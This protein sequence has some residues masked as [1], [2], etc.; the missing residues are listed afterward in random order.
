MTVEAHKET[1]DFQAEVSQVLNLVIRSLYS[2][3]EIFLRE[4]VSNAS[5]A[6]EKL[7][8]EAL[9]DEALFEDDPELRVRVTLD[10]EAGTVTISDNGIG[11][12]RQEVAETIGTIA[13]SGTR[14]FFEAMSGDQTKDS[15][16][17]GQFGVGFYSA[18]IVADKVTLLTRR[19]GLGQEHGV[20]WESDGEGSF[21]IENVDKATRGTDVVLHLREDE[22]E[23]IE[24]YR[25]R[26]IISKFSDHITIPVEME[27]EHYGEDEEKP[28][29]AEFERVNK[30]TALWMRNR[31]DISEEEYHEFYKHVSHDFE[32]P[33]THVHNKVEGNNE[34]TALL[35]IPQRAPFDLWDR[36]Q[37]HGVKLFVRRVFI[38]DEADKLMPRYLRF[39]KGVVDSDDLP[40]NVSREILQHN[41]K[42][43]TIRQANVKRIMSALEKLAESDKEKYQ[44]FWDEFGKV[45]KEGP[46][47]DYANRDRIAGLLRF[48]TTHNETDEQ[49][50]S[51]ADYVSRMQEGQDKIYYITADSPAAARFSPH[52]EV[53]KKK[54]V[55]VLLLS[56]RVDEWLVTSLTESDGKQLQSVAKGA[57]DLG[58]LE[59]KEEKESSEKQSEEHKELLQRMQDVLGEAVKEIRVSQRLTDSP[60]CLVVEEHDMSANLARV[61]KSV[62]QDAPQTKPIM[63][64]N[65]EHPLVERLEGEQDGDKFGD[66]TKVLFDQAQLAEGGQLDDPAAFVRRLNSLMLKLTAG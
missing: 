5:D 30:G 58:E 62:G 35:Y 15:E 21:T 10:K 20:R 52:L 17:I 51:L 24:S 60:A 16:L 49:N 63:E 45:M 53:L 27:K 26:S 14:K 6:A 46:A 47:E 1:L 33:L 57:L 40:L 22:K 39:V 64:I 11:M 59:D 36:D 9:T 29:T 34:Y 23:F 43:D 61:L 4:L 37:K 31:S 28:K 54:G 19:A 18:F 32:N 42:I 50:V 66:L 2:N 7:R 65:A 25:L 13:S 55:E 56:D 12:S 8:F 48:A 38:M 3:K 41:R 44:T